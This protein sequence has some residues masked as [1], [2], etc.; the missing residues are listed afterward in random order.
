MSRW[1]GWHG[2]G[3]ERC[4]TL[5]RAALARQFAVLVG[6]RIYQDLM[7]EKVSHGAAAG[8]TATG[9][10]SPKTFLLLLLQGAEGHDMRNS[11]TL[12][13]HAAFK[14]FPPPEEQVQAMSRCQLW[15]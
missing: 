10:C 2:K 12:L 9:W 5:L 4:S 6:E 3:D 14:S 1:A 13:W 7:Y 15:H 11:G 8:R